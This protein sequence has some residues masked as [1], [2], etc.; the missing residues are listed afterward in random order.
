[1]NA[2]PGPVTAVSAPPAS[3]S[4]ALSWASPVGGSLTGVMIRRTTG[5]TAPTSPTD[6]TLVADVAKPLTTYTDTSLGSGTQLFAHDGTAASA[7][8]ATVTTTTLVTA[9][10]VST[11]SYHSCAVTTAG[12]VRCW[13]FNGNGRLGDGTLTDRTT[14]VDVATLGA[15]SGAAVVSSGESHTCAVTSAGA[16]WCWGF[17]GSCELGNGTFAD[18]SSVPE[19]VT[20]LGAGSG[21]V[22]LSSGGAHTCAVTSAGALRCWGYNGCAQ[23]GDGLTTDSYVP[24]LVTGLGPVTAVAAGNNRTCALTDTGEVL[25]RGS[26]GNGQLGDGTTNDSAT[27][28]AII[29]PGSGVASISAGGYHSCD[30][31]LAHAVQCWAPTAMA[32]SATGPP[33]IVGRR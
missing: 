14:P 9:S 11:G 5:G 2:V 25:C 29:G 7:A 31:T 28:V 20:G 17:S 8:A 22:A 19:P 33:R 4:I 1:M 12:G 13:G 18:S 26:N 10:M 6:G 3:T 21:V 30:L 23:L 32:R 15:G 27:P 24:V 16:V